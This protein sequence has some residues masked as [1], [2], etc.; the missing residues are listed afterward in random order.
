VLALGGKDGKVLVW[1]IVSNASVRQRF[2]TGKK[3]EDYAG[4]DEALEKMALDGQDS[5]DYSDSEEEEAIKKASGEGGAAKG[6]AQKKKKKN[7]KDKASKP[8]K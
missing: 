5:S 6:K 4:V 3:D 8:K 7:N 2:P 1:D